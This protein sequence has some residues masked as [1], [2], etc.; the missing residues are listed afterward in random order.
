MRKSGRPCG[1]KRAKLQSLRN[2]SALI[3][4]NLGVYDFD[5]TSKT[6][7][8]GAF[9]SRMYNFSKKNEVKIQQPLKN[10]TSKTLELACR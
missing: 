7:P 4:V 10:Y 2:K 3:Y 5:G 9:P 6:K 1:N 8:R